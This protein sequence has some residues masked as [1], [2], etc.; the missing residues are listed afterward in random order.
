MHDHLKNVGHRLVH[1]PAHKWLAGLTKGLNGNDFDIASVYGAA[2]AAPSFLSDWFTRNAH[3]GSLN[4]S[5]AGDSEEFLYA[6][7]LA[8]ETEAGLYR[9]MMGIS[10]FMIPSDLIKQVCEANGSNITTL[11]VVLGKHFDQSVLGRGL[12]QY[13]SLPE[14]LVV[15]L[16]GTQT[17]RNA[18]EHF[19]YSTIAP[20]RIA[21][22]RRHCPIDPWFQRNAPFKRYNI[23]D[24][25]LNV[26]PCWLDV[27]PPS[28]V[29]EYHCVASIQF[30]G[31]TLGG[32]Y[33]TTGLR[34]TPDG[35]PKMMLLDDSFVDQRE[36]AVETSR[37][38]ANTH[39]YVRAKPNK[40]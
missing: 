1:E 8:L 22:D 24:T 12:M 30:S 39:F 16:S 38:Y 3:M 28:E 9:P 25:T 2:G 29:L 11:E 26:I 21:F 19:P 20:Y 10:E 34:R 7:K 13:E 17:A 37:F 18:V 14:I 36:D 31:D 5:V 6:L 15:K 23:N 4:T 33:K 40:V 27:T 32:H 35:T